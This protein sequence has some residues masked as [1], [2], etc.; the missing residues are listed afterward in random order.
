VENN[1][2]KWELIL[3]HKAE[4]KIRA[5]PAGEHEHIIAAL[6]LLMT[7]PERT[8][9]KAMKG[10]DKGKSRQRIG[11]WR[12]IFRV[13]PEK[14]IIWVTDFGARGDVYKK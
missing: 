5:L 12:A 4:R 2:K 3:S 11:K 13:D 14:R 8:D 10:R 1:E 6:D 9:V 7:A